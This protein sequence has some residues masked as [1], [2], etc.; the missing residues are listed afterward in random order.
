LDGFV[1]GPKERAVHRVH[2]VHAVDLT[3]QVCWSGETHGDMNAADHQDCFLGFHLPCNVSGQS[4]VAGINLACFQRASKR[5]L[6][7]TGRGRN[8][9]VLG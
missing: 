2:F 3:S 8:D 6:L 4:S 5:A 1:Q 7:S 9:I